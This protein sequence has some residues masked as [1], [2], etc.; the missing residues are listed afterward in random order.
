MDDEVLQFVKNEAEGLLSTM[1]KLYDSNEFTDVKLKVGDALFPV[2]K[3]VLYHSSLM[4]R[5]LL[6]SETADKYKD[7]IEL[8]GVELEHLKE[9]LRYMY[10]NKIDI[11]PK[12]IIGILSTADYFQMDEVKQFCLSTLPTFLSPENAL[13]YFE[14][15]LLYSD[16]ALIKKAVAVIHENL[17]SLKS[18]L[19]IA[20]FERILKY[21]PEDID[22]GQPY[23]FMK[24]WIEHDLA[25]RKQYF[26]RL[27]K[28]FDYSKMSNVHLKLM[29]ADDLMK[30]HPDQREP[31]IELLLK[32]VEELEAKNKS[33]KVLKGTVKCTF[34]DV[35]DM[36][37][38]V[39]IFGDNSTFIADVLWEMDIKKTEKEGTEYFAFYC[40]CKKRNDDS[41]WSRK[42]AVKYT[43]KSN[44][45]DL[46][47]QGTQRT[48][49]SGSNS[50]GYSTFI[51]WEDLMDEE[52]GYLSA[53]GSITLQL[54]IE[55]D[56][57]L[58]G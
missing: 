14:Y 4:L 12:D 1:K 21:L 13:S 7:V 56:P 11:K 29:A 53:N 26:V 34:T 39:N 3:A 52:L 51:K 58:N 44:V 24:E 23:T 2:H 49:K 47:K 16:Q 9:I 33:Y 42:A 22:D 19:D 36:Q 55:V 37:K 8:K 17:S 10:T 54:D 25:D 5:K 50:W 41:D 35:K 15:G 28:N 32:A 45:K 57:V 27:M 43:L 38:D 31:I 46:T 18:T 40:N 48:Y 30:Q 6:T 20:A